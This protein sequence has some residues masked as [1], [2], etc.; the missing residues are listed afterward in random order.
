[1]PFADNNVANGVALVRLSFRSTVVVDRIAKAAYYQQ[2]S[3]RQLRNRMEDLGFDIRPSWANGALILAPIF[4]Q[5]L[6]NARIELNA[7]SVLLLDS[8]TN[9]VEQ[10]LI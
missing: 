10:A 1:M 4:R 7:Y 8:D 5:Q 2:G 3:L 9:L 6:H